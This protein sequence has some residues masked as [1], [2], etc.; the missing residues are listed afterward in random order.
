MPCAGRTLV[1]DLRNPV[2]SVAIPG[3]VVDDSSR[4]GHNDQLAEGVVGAGFGACRCR[5]DGFHK[6]AWQTTW[7]IG[8]GELG[9]VGAGVDV[10]EALPAIKVVGVGRRSSTGAGSTCRGGACSQRTLFAVIVERV[11]S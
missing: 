2:G 10:G 9:F 6:L 3:E 8:R 5:S 11:V 7:V 4:S 1:D